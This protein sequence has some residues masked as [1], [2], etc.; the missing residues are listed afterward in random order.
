[1]NLTDPR[2]SYIII[3]SEK[4]NDIMSI[5]WAKEFKVIPIKGFY[6]G[7]YENAII[8]YSDIDNDELRKEILFILS[9]F[10]ERSAII[11]YLDETT[12]NEIFNDGSEKLM[13]VLMYNT[14]DDNKSY[15][16]NGVSFSFIEEKRYWSPK[17]VGDFKIGMI[18]EYLDKNK[19]LK[20]EI[21]DP[22][23]EYNNFLKL[24]MKYDKLRVMSV[25]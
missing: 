4:I 7:E 13:G 21:K 8:A 24:F 5:L 18:V 9:H 1:M 6:K 23:Q 16:M 3:S 2:I 10:K 17:A 11:K 25:N 20:H 19:W 22:T 14:D 12:A 15:L